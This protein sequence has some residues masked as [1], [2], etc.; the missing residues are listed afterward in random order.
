MHGMPLG[1]HHEGPQTFA[2][3]TPACG[4]QMQADSASSCSLSNALKSFICCRHP[5]LNAF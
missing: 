2:P 5:P 3:P 4:N 1:F